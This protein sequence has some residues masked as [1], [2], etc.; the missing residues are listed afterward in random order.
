MMLK[1][2]AINFQENNF[3]I[4]I[5]PPTRIL[6]AIDDS[7]FVTVS[8]DTIYSGTY[9]VSND[10]LKFH[11]GEQENP[12]LFHYQLEGD[13]LHLMLFPINDSSEVLLFELNSFLWG[14]TNCK[15]S[16]VFTRI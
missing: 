15:I 9:S 11:I 16:G 2:T 1:K 3:E 14:H 13:S 10:T 8:S 12:K 6:T 5:L 7:I 4:K